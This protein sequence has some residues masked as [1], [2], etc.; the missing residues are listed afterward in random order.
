MSAWTTVKMR[1]ADY[2][3]TLGAMCGAAMMGPG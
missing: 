1:R 3:S 2:I